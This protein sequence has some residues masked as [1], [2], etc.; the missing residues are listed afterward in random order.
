M[1]KE[2]KTPT[3]KTEEQLKKEREKKAKEQRA[4]EEYKRRY[5]AY[6]DDIKIS[7]REDW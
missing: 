7:H 4:I 1:V 3:V 2:T 5:F 6:Y